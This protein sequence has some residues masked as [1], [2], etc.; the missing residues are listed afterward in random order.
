MTEHLLI[1]L[2][3]IISLG[4]GAQW[5]A[6]RIR[7]PA[8]LL[9]LVAG[10]IAGP[11]TGFLEPYKLFGNLVA[12]IVSLAVA[13][14]LF[15][16]GLSLK[17]SE[18]RVI[19]STVTKLVTI[20]V[21][22]C[23][24]ATSAAC[25]YILGMDT[26]LSLLLGAVLVV[27]GPTVIV[28]LLRHIRPEGKVGSILKWEGIVIDPIGASLAVLVF[29]AMFDAHK[30][31]VAAEVGIS[32]L[33]TL[34]IG[35]SL[36]VIGAGIIITVFRYHLVPD[37]LHNSLTLTVAILMHTASNLMQHESGLFTVTLMGVLLANQKW[38]EV[39]HIIAFK[40]DL[41]VLLISSLFIIL[42][43]S[44]EIESLK[45]ILNLNSLLFIL[46]LIFLIRP[47]AVL[48][49][50][51]TSDI[52]RNEK[53][54]LSSIAPR[55]IVAAAVSSV[56]ALKLSEI[57]YPGHE[58]LVSITFLVISCTVAVY[59]LSAVHVSRALNLANPN[60]QGVLIAGAHRWVREI[61][62]ILQ[63]KGFKVLLVDTNRDN[64]VKTRQRG[65]NTEYIN[66]LAEDI[67]D[68]IDLN[69]IGRFL[70]LTPNDE[71]NSLASIHF[72]E[73]FS[74]SKVY[75]LTDGSN[76][77]KIGIDDE[78]PRSLKG[79]MLFSQD[80]TYDHITK[81]FNDGWIIK[82]AQITDEFDFQKYKDYY[83]GNLIP[84][85]LVRDNTELIVCTADDPPTPKSEDII[86]AL[87]NDQSAN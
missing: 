66:I 58:M 27:T 85:F 55:G 30:G 3:S 45:Q 37:F 29:T 28:P 54:F 2:A 20:G 48:I 16:G 79:R 38:V 68:K 74:M 18:F 80:A 17:Y 49:S 8:I 61:A 53:I 7:L 19:G 34:V 81:L 62:A 50:T 51:F 73:I 84:M 6:W 44:L 70:A 65:L 57:N 39:K 24:T 64:I 10:F 63:E 46:V 11:I 22:V 86:I 26:K 78:I 13:V 25:Y 52:T 77:E 40:E 76:T 1:G 32:L 67:E 41:R 87:V 31:E 72:S 60:P 35:V 43:A 9:L 4:I 33:K 71:V 14:I 42:A 47:L 21:I 82:K 5:L 75:Q 36:G 59:G 83:N 69:G 12:P 23:W 56:F 15:E